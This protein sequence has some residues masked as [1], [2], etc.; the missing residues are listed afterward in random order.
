MQSLGRAQ[1]ILKNLAF[2]SV[3][4]VFSRILGLVTLVYLA[5]VLQP[6]AFGQ[7]N[8]ALSFLSFFSVLAV[9]GLDTVGTRALA[10]NNHN[11]E[12]VPAISALKLGI[13]LIMLLLVGVIT[14]CVNKDLDIKLLIILCAFSLPITTF[15]DW[16]FQGLQRMEFIALS[17]VMT[18]LVFLGML[19]FTV[20]GPGQVFMVPVGQFLSFLFPSVILGMI[21]RR[22][23][24]QYLIPTFPLRGMYSLIKEATPLFLVNILNMVIYH[25][26][27]VMIGFYQEDAAVGYFTAAYRIVMVFILLEGMIGTT[28]FPAICQSY[29][30]SKNEAVKMIKQVVRVLLFIAMPLTIIIFFLASQIV[31]LVFGNRYME[32]VPQILK[33]IIWMVPL[34]FIGSTCA[35]GMLAWGQDKPYLAVLI[36]A[37]FASMLLSVILVPRHGLLGASLVP[38]FTQ[39]ITMPVYYIVFAKKQRILQAPFLTKVSIASLSMAAVMAMGA[40]WPAVPRAGCAILVFFLGL[41]LL[42]EL[43]REDLKMARVLVNSLMGKG[44]PGTIKQP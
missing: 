43:G 36:I 13:G 10:Q 6:A 22:T 20:H 12:L 18:Q 35:R 14:A 42:K 33:V 5:R 32:E 21:L 9:F 3:S 28:M 44:R 15:Y 17:S 4:Q 30:T 1:V 11:G 26:N 31:F 38:V 29:V 8:F 25:L 41:I 24:N 19:I 27:T 37:G 2:M 34:V 23:F 39:V 16:V 7:F 40:S